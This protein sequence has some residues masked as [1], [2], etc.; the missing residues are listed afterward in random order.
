MPAHRSAPASWGD[1]PPS[2]ERITAAVTRAEPKVRAEIA[3]LFGPDT[4]V[5]VIVRTPQEIDLQYAP[6]TSHS[7]ASETAPAGE[8][9]AVG[10]KTK[11]LVDW[12]PA[13]DGGTARKMTDYRV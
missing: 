7:P 10:R 11:W 4:E 13:T 5:R 1:W 2:Q 3:R 8:I 9:H 6:G 12:N